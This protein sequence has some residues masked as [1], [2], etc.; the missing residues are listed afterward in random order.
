VTSPAETEPV[1]AKPKKPKKDK[2]RWWDRAKDAI[3]RIV[4]EDE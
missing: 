4:G 1:E 3:E 2:K